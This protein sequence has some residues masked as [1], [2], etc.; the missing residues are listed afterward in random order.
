MIIV[1]GPRMEQ[2]GFWSRCRVGGQEFSLRGHVPDPST[3][4]GDPLGCEKRRRAW[5]V[6][7]DATGV[8]V[9]GELGRRTAAA[10]F[11]TVDGP[12][13]KWFRAVRR[14]HPGLRFMLL[15]A[16]EAW[17][18]KGSFGGIGF[19]G[20]D[21]N[22]GLGVLVGVFP[23]FAARSAAWLR[24]TVA[25]VNAPAVALARSKKGAGGDLAAAKRELRASHGILL[26]AAAIGL[27]AEQQAAGEV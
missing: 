27:N 15:F 7:R 6:E 20:Q 3:G 9:L 24:M 14:T 1:E 10:R 19:H 13:G 22:P 2:R 11:E 17:G 8:K 21:Q 12:P 5:G 18:I 23:D 4:E 25:K 26:I 16:D